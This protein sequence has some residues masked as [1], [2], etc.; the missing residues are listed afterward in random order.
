MKNIITLLAC[1]LLVFSVEAQKKVKPPNIKKAKSL[2]SKGEL[3]EAKTMIDIASEHE[4]T[5]NDGNTWYYRGLIYATIDTTSN[6]A[7][8]ALS[9]NP[10]EI[11]VAS[12]EKAQKMAPE[13]TEY[14]IYDPI[15]VVITTYEEQINKYYSHYFQI[16]VNHYEKDELLEASTNFELAGQ[17]LKS[18]TSALINAAYSAQGVEDEE[19]ASKLF[20]EAIER[21][22]RA[23]TV[24]YNVIYPL[25]ESEDW[26]GALDWVTKAKELYPTDNSLG[27]FEVTS[28]LKLGRVDQAMVQLEEAIKNNPD[29]ADL[30]FSLALLYDQTDR[31]EEA[32]TFYQK[33]LEVDPNHYASNFNIAVIKF[34]FANELYKKLT[35]LTTSAEDRKTEQELLPQIK[36]GFSASLPYWEKCYEVKNDDVSSIQTLAFIYDFLKMK[37]KASVLNKI[38]DDM[39]E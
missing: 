19:R 12:F 29:E 31:N 28:L 25:N 5:R 2:W 35:Q 38:L 8:Q 13:G 36:E 23:I 22:A 39:K 20:I 16:A 37:D 30:R 26:Q 9:D 15:N 24:Y 14:S 17:V 34:G 18:D 7:F 21:G 27:R 6:E 33:V 1:F 4:K 10:L 11:A 32:L 3:V